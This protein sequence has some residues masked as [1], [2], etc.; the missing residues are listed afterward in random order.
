MDYM[1]RGTAGN[2]HVRIFSCVS[3]EICETAREIHDTTP[4]AT[5]LTG[6][7]LDQCGV[8]M[9]LMMKNDS[10]VLSLSIRAMGQ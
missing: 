1:V 4:N 6:E 5:C 2:G 8:M 10:A 9:G 7:T 3:K